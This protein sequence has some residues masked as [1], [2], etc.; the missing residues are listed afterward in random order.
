VWE[1]ETEAA[2]EGSL[3]VLND[4]GSLNQEVLYAPVFGDFEDMYLR[5]SNS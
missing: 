3:K 4:D 2:E 5:C 1:F